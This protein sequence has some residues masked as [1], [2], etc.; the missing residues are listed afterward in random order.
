MLCANVRPVEAIALMGT[1]QIVVG[2]EGVQVALHLQDGYVPVLRAFDAKAFID[3]G[4]VHMLDKAVGV[5]SAHAGNAMLDV[6]DR[7][8]QFVRM[9]VE[10]AAELTLVVGENGLHG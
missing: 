3:E 8:Q 7:E 6:F 1:L 5:R 4:A 2:H 10:L 9:R